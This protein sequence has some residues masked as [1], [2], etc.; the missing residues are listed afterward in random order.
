[1]DESA[2]RQRFGAFELDVAAQ[3]VVLE[4]RAELVARMPGDNRHQSRLVVLA[5]LFRMQHIHSYL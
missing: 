3:G 2:R 4:D 1:M 5:W